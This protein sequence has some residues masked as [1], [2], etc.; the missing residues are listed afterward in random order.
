MFTTVPK[1]FAHTPAIEHQ[2]F[3]APTYILINSLDDTYLVKESDRIS[4]FK[5]YYKTYRLTQDIC[6]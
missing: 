1:I 5:L 6:S 3:V 4:S 2:T